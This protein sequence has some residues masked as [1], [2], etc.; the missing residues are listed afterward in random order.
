[1]IPDEDR[2][3]IGLLGLNNT[4]PACL[5]HGGRNVPRSHIDSHEEQTVKLVYFM[6]EEISLEAI[7]TPTGKRPSAL[8]CIE[9]RKKHLNRHAMAPVFLRCEAEG[10]KCAYTPSRGGCCRNAT[11]NTNSCLEPSAPN[12][13]DFAA[14]QMTSHYL[15]G[16]LPS[17][18]KLI[19][20]NRL[21]EHL[22]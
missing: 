2:T 1:M 17:R 13:C 6:A 3:K 16:L 18:N 15:P 9:C 11:M 7:L 8:A 19:R 14:L 12:P 5:F 21:R 20:S 22:R 4:S 10:R